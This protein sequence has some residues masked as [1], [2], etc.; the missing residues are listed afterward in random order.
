MDRDVLRL[1]DPTKDW[2]IDKTDHKIDYELTIIREMVEP[3]IIVISIPV[4]FYTIAGRAL[5]TLFPQIAP[6]TKVHP[7]SLHWYSNPYRLPVG[8]W[9]CSSDIVLEINETAYYFFLRFYIDTAKLS[10][11]KFYDE[12]L[13]ALRDASRG[14]ICNLSENETFISADEDEEEESLVVVSYEDN[15]SFEKVD[16]SFD[17]FFSFYPD[18]TVL[19]FKRVIQMLDTIA[20][21]PGSGLHFS[22]LLAGPPGTGKSLFATLLA[23]YA[24]EE[25]KALVVFTSGISGI[26]VV[27]D[28]I[29]LFPLV[30]FIFDEC[31]F[32]AQN[33]ERQATRELISL[34]QLM[35]SYAYKSYASWGILFT[36]N[37]PHTIDP[38]FLR[39][40]R[41]DE[42]IELTPIQDSQLGYKLFVYHCHKLGIE[43][44]AGLDLKIFEGRTHAECAALAHKIYRMEKFGKKV[45]PEEIKALAKDI[46]KWS[47][48]QKIRS[49]IEDKAGF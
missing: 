22:A 34:M 32:L 43:P 37:R 40:M 27:Y 3:R 12:F 36:T 6:Y 18:D 46:A 20:A 45:T 9:Q 25:K 44:P 21:E 5:K 38:A 39:P 1:I 17:E 8:Y 42:L 11:T 14:V 29:K 23:K 4:A 33:R 49:G 35:D 10:P 15:A 47:R 26:D 31:E 2:V 19:A 48:P 30:L 41:L 13:K 16:I 7:R 24:V 28:G